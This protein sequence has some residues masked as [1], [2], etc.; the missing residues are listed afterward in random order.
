LLSV[1]NSI[2][3][4]YL[5]GSFPTAYLIVKRFTGKNVFRSGDKNMGG[6][7]ALIISKSFT[8]ALLVG[9]VDALKALTACLIVNNFFIQSVWW[10]G[11]IA[12]FF[13][14]LGHNY[15]IFMNFKGGKG[16]S[17]NLGAFLF[18]NPLMALLFFSILLCTTFVNKFFRFTRNEFS[19]LIARLTLFAVSAYLIFN[20]YWIHALVLQL[21]SVVKYL[22]NK[23]WFKLLDYP[24]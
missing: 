3:I 11:L 21:V 2:I 5:L 10:A 19:E 22:T 8:I 24:F 6:T 17:T 20:D 14:T 12:G 23:E 13:S 16:A 1:L 7:N 15:S 9:V 18:L 4:S